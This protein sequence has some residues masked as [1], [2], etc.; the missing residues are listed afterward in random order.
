MGV[1]HPSIPPE[2]VLS[3]ACYGCC[4]SLGP[5]PG[6][7]LP[8]RANELIRG[9]AALYFAPSFGGVPHSA[10]TYHMTTHPLPAEGFPLS[11]HFDI[12]RRF[13]SVSR[14]GVEPVTPLSVE[15]GDVPEGA[16]QL[17]AAFLSDTGLL[18]EEAA[19]KFKPTPLAMQFINT[20]LADEERGRRLL[21]TVV[22]KLWFGRAAAAFLQRNPN[23]DGPQ[24]GNALLKEADASAAGGRAKVAVLQEYLV[25]TGLTAGRAGSESQTAG[26]PVS[27]P[28][29]VRRPGKPVNTGKPEDSGWRVL[30]TDDFDLRIRPDP[31]AVR[32]LRKHLELLEEEIRV[33]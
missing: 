18:I 21:R 2:D 15:G 31:A 25:Y 6:A 14:N 5:G 3:G 28:R 26:A 24:L 22:A 33:G 32:R 23:A 11:V 20:K 9:P 17:N 29:A 19:G 27:P 30:S 13:M 4:T 8:L 12:L 16:A 7:T 1:I 10:R